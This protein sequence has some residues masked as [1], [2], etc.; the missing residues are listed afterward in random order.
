MP[1]ASGEAAS[2]HIV[3]DGGFVGS[4]LASP[5]WQRLAGVAAAGFGGGQGSG[6]CAAYHWQLFGYVRRRARINGQFLH[7]R[8]RQAILAQ[9]QR[10]AADHCLRV[11]CSSGQRA[12]TACW[13][14]RLLWHA[15]HCLRVAAAPCAALVCV[16]HAAPA[17]PLPLVQRER[18][19]G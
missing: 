5:H 19:P 16:L 9:Q 17:Q 10:P 3:F 18:P 13:L 1:E 14:Q 7:M 11:S 2:V 6:G 8:G 15:D 12:I 4:C